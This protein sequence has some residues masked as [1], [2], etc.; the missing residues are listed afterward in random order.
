MIRLIQRLHRPE[1]QIERS[2]TYPFLHKAFWSGLLTEDLEEEGAGINTRKI[3]NACYFLV[4]ERFFDP[5]LWEA[6]YSEKFM[7]IFE[8]KNITKFNAADTTMLVQI[9]TSLRLEA[10][11][12]FKQLPQQGIE[13][14]A[15]HYFDHI[16][17]KRI[18]QLKA[19]NK[20]HIAWKRFSTFEN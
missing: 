3:L 15:Y 8:P 4:L 14:L 18:Q 1:K 17:V 10:P 16:K 7:R 9:L 12:V 13:Q 19:W 6:H 20:H 5:D 2:S 11:W